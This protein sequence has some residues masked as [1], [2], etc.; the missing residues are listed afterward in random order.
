MTSPLSLLVT[1]QIG[2][3]Y[4]GVGAIAS[5]Y[6]LAEKKSPSWYKPARGI[7]YQG[8]STNYLFYWY[9]P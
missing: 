3:P 9:S 7:S 4:L 2:M 8:A 5:T 6:F 1:Y